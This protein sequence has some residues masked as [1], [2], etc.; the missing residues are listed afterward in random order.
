MTDK[1]NKRS[2]TDDTFSHTTPQSRFRVGIGQPWSVL[3]IFALAIGASS[4]AA[5]EQAFDVSSG[6]AAETLNLFARQAGVSVVYRADRIAGYETNA[7]EGSYPPAE[8]LGLMLAD[9]GLELVEGQ[10]KAFAVQAPE[11][12]SSPGNAQTAPGATLMAQASGNRTTTSPSSPRNESANS[13]VSGTVT[14]ARTGAGLKGALVTIEETDQTASTDELGNFRF[15]GVA[16]GEYTLRVSFLGYAAQS[17]FIEARDGR[18]VAERFVLS[19]GSDVEEIIVYGARSARAQSLNQE[20]TAP[21]SSTV[22]TSD[23]LGRF[24]GVTISEVLRRAPGVTFSESSVTGEG[25]NITVRGLEPNLNQVT[26]NGLRLPEGSGV[27]RAADLS[28]ILSGAISKVTIN[29]TLLPSQDSAGSG[30]LVQIETKSPLDRARRYASF[31]WEGGRTEGDL[32]RDYLASGTI[33]GKFGKEE[34]VGLSASVQ[35][36]SRDVESISYNSTSYFLGEYLPVDVNGDPI[37]S[38]DQINPLE[39][40]PFESG[41]DSIFPRSVRNSYNRANLE[42][43]S[44]SLSAAWDVS[45]HTQLRTDYTRAEEVLD[46]YSRAVTADAFLRR[47][48][49]PVGVLGGEERAVLVAEDV[50]AAAG[51]PDSLLSVRHNY[52][53]TEDIKDTT[54]TLSFRGNTNYGQFRIGYELGWASASLEEPNSGDF[55]LSNAIDGVQQSL[56]LSV[57][58]DL[59]SGYALANLTSDG[60]VVSVYA[61]YSS[62]SDFVLPSLNEAGFALFNDPENYIVNSIS[63]EAE[64]Q[65]ENERTT[66]RFSVAYDLADSFLRSVEGGL[67]YESAEFT[68][69]PLPARG[70]NSNIG[71]P[72][73]DFGLRFTENNLSSIGTDGGFNMLSLSEIQEF[74]A[75]YAAAAAELGFEVDENTP[76]DPR[77]RDAFTKEDNFAAYLQAHFDIGNVEVLAGL[78]YDRVKLRAKNVQFPFIAAV[79]FSRITEVEDRLT[80]LSDE[81]VTQDAFLP[82]VLLTY[83]RDKNTLFRLGYSESVARP[84]IADISD[85]ASVT[86]LLAPF[87]GP[88]FNQPI[89]SLRQ[90]NAAIEPARMR[91]LD[92]S[93][94]RYFDDVGQIEVSLFYKKFENLL[95][96]N[97]LTQEEGLEVLADTVFGSDP[98]FQDLPENTFVVVTIPRNSRDSADVWGV[99]LVVEKQLTGLSGFL[100]GLG[101]LA[102]YTYTDSSRTELEVYDDPIEGRQSLFIEDVPFSGDPRHSGTAAITYNKYGIDANLS[103]TMQDRRYESFQPHNLPIYRERDDSLDFRA[104]FRFAGYRGDWRFWIQ[105]SDLLKGTGDSDVEIS[106]GGFNGTQRFFTD[107]NF[108]GGRELRVGIASTF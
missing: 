8:A 15:P 100:S 34:N 41:V 59:L 50:L 83:R 81:S 56:G 12:G 104:E 88:N 24:D 86:V 39:S 70:F 1:S 10:G 62:T 49:L 27:G 76:S 26:L 22:L 17:V 73:S 64:D 97:V 31:S 78:R 74:I 99:E 58:R 23:F 16:P 46:R 28:N 32:L 6:E 13:V 2:T 48:I 51:F 71:A 66:A 11:E 84:S 38:E 14:D 5:D 93:F 85:T 108:L 68:N 77:F 30:G 95:D 96:T 43:L 44:V 25:T 35:Y 45:G 72:L 102:N 80:T 61:P 7:V 106:Q 54:N 98:F 40:F 89:V 90:G 37:T 3:V 82:R 69:F 60:R 42:N 33:S 75:G 101:L 87:S 29:K 79:D 57:P 18:P 92:V 103:Y 20:R 47:E 91:S 63:T 52:S 36:R 53:F 94:E 9:T 107:V 55:G 21:N 67:F 65:G 105:G 4:A 19:G